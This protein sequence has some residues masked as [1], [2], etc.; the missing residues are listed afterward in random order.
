MQSGVGIDLM[1]PEHSH[2]EGVQTAIIAVIALMAGALISYVYM[3]DQVS[4]LRG[5][6]SELTR[7]I[8]T[9]EARLTSANERG[10]SA[11]SEIEALKADLDDKTKLIESQ[12]ARIIQLEAASRSPIPAPPQ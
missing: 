12:Q 6:V 8:S 5:Q 3:Q 9:M 11:I 7:Q 1:G 4:D 10:R 2:N